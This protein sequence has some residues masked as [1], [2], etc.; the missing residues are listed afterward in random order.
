[1][2]SAQAEGE[3]GPGFA[4]FL[5]FDGTLVEI[6]P[7]PDSVVVA[8]E[9]PLLLA[10]LRDRLGGA[11][12]IVTGRSIA[13]IDHFLPGLG[14]DACGMH[15]LERRVGGQVAFPEGL[16][17]LRPRIAELRARLSP[18]P[19]LI[20][21]DK[22]IGVAVHW[23]MA[24]EAEAEAR[25]AIDALAAELGPAYKIQEGKAVREIVPAQAGKGEGIRALMQMAPYGGRRPVFIGDDRTDEHGFDAVNRMGGVTVKIGPG[26]T[27][28]RYRL[29][30]PA[31]LR[32]AMSGWLA[33]RLSW[34]DLQPA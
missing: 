1:M 28:A 27:L 3:R 31:E 16:A 29:A 22:R 26:E 19:G 12:A 4:L 18:H 21:E 9:L 34:E 14:L 15:G 8:P 10:A 32:E 30:T 17:D 33:G 7:T 23:R 24:P 6:A 13:G 25:A 5:D 20:V 2:D 11:L